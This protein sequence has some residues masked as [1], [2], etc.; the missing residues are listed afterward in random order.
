MRSATA[1]PT[2][3]PGGLSAAAGGGEAG[4]AGRRGAA[5][6][7]DRRGAEGRAAAGPAAAAMLIRVT[8]RISIDDGGAAGGFPAGLG[9]RRAEHP[10]GGDRG[11]APLRRRPQ[12]QPAGAGAAAAAAA[13]RP[14]DHRGGRAGHHRP[15]PPHPGPQPGGRA[16]TPAG[17]DPGSRGAAAAAAPADPSRP[18]GRR[19]AGSRARRSAATS[20]GCAGGPIRI[21]AG[22]G[23][24]PA[25]G[26]QS[27]R[28]R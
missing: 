2:S 18:W 13:R 8:P 15:A 10:E 22:R 11:P 5:A 25:R 4:L 27:A 1:S 6:G 23:G 21:S 26:R 7:R 20:S 24:T 19:P 3:A 28:K 9:R 12:P 17:A 16:G 14:A